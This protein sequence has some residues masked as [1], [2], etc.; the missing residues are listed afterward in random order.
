MVVVSDDE[1][2]I[3]PFSPGGRT[4]NY[5]LEVGHQISYGVL[6]SYFAHSAIPHSLSSTP[7]VHTQND[8]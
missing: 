4:I 8:T 2:V 1:A 7:I 6:V 3:Y 5:S